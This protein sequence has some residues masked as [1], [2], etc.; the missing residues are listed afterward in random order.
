[1]LA[2]SVTLSHR[3][4]TLPVMTPVSQV[5]TLLYFYVRRE[6]YNGAGRQ[7]QKVG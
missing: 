2:I 7:I 4:V 3:H 6:V 1:M 5:A